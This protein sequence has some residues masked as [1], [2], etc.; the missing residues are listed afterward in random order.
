MCV[1]F[2]RFG[3]LQITALQEEELKRSEQ[4]VEEF[5]RLSDKT[6]RTLFEVQS[7][8]LAEQVGF[9]VD[10]PVDVRGRWGLSWKAGYTLTRVARGGFFNVGRHDLMRCA[11][12]Y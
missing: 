6:E 4:S 10:G 5:R 9:P 3:R 2:C 1:S 11:R 8:R 12:V 7:A